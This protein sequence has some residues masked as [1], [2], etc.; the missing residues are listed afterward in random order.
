MRPRQPRSWVPVVAFTLGLEL[1]WLVLCAIVAVV[2]GVAYG[3]MLVLAGV[4]IGASAFQY[5]EMRWGPR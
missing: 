3:A 1:P 5:A 4:L 2:G